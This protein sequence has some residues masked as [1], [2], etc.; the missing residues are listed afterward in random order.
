M[1]WINSPGALTEE[2]MNNNADICINLLRN[3]AIDDSTIASL[4]ANWESE[5]GINPGR[6]EVGGAGYGLIQWT[7]QS[8]LID[9]AGV[10]GLSPYTDGNV[11]VQVAIGEV[12]GNPASINEWYTSEGFIS[13]YY[14]SGATPDMIGITGSQFLENSMGW[15]SEKLVIMYM[16]GRERPSYNPET[17]HYQQRIENAT[18]WF[19]YMGGHPPTPK[20]DKPVPGWNVSAIIQ[21]GAIA[22]TIRRRRII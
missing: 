11:Q 16:V 20:P 10:M 18:K 12:A 5:S 13:P 1:P 19:A 9:H 6:Y 14:N 8:V 3:M 15:S 17:N 4:L 2:Q 7:P 21:W 22:E